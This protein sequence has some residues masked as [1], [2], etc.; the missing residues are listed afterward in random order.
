MFTGHTSKVT[1]L[2]AGALVTGIMLIASLAWNYQGLQKEFALQTDKQIQL[3]ASRIQEI[4]AAES[5]MTTLFMAGYY[6][7][8][9][10]FRIL[11]NDSMARNP[12]IRALIY[13]PRVKEDELAAHE[14]RVREDGI[15]AYSVRSLAMKKAGHYYPI[16]YL[17]PFT[18][19]S[20]RSLGI[21]IGNSAHMAAARDRT[22]ESGAPVI[23]YGDNLLKGLSGGWLIQA[24]YSTRSLPYSSELRQQ[25]AS[26]IVALLINGDELV[27]GLI[28]EGTAIRI[29]YSD[30][31]DNTLHTL[32][33]SGHGQLASM[34]PLLTQ[35]TRIP[36]A[37]RA[38]QLKLERSVS[39]IELVA[40][41]TFVAL[42]AG[43]ILTLLLLNL[44]RNRNAK[45][46]AEEA[47][48][49]S[50]AELEARVIERTRDLK[51]SNAQLTTEIRE[52]KH[53]QKELERFKST[54]DQT[55]DCVFMFDPQSLRFFYVNEGAIEQVGYSFDEMTAMTPLDIKPEFD[56]PRF[57]QMSDSLIK[58]PAHSHT[59]ETIHRHKDGH[60]IPVEIFLQYIEPDDTPPRFLAIVRDI[61]E[62][63]QAESERE[64]L[65]SYV[66]EV[67]DSMPSI[68]AG[69]DNTGHITHW[70]RQAAQLSGFTV[71][72][73]L[74]QPISKPLPMLSTK[75]NE[76]IDAV[77]TGKKLKLSRM[78]YQHNDETH[79]ADIL[80]YPL[81]LVGIEGA[82]LRIDDVTEQ[83]R[84]EE[85]MVQTEKMLSVGGLAGG[86]AHELN[87][88]IG[89]MVQG[90]QNIRRRLSTS[91]SKNTETASR[92]GISLE[93][94][95][96]Y[97][98]E[99]GVDK[100]FETVANAGERASGIVNNM[101]RFSRKSEMTYQTIQVGE[102][103][104]QT[105]AL[106]AV[107]Y[108]LTKQYDFRAIIIERDYQEGLPPFEC[109]P[110]ELQ[111]VIL[112]L[113]RNAAQAF[114]EQPQ[115][116]GPPCITLRTREAHGQ[117]EITVEDNGPGMDEMT[118]TRAFEPFF[119]TKPPG[120]GTGLGLSVSYYI[121]HDEHSGE[122]KVNSTPGNGAKF[123]ITLPFCRNE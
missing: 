107:D 54:L 78:S 73:A 102:L 116:A 108:D 90:I 19:L 43:A 47:L 63:R 115:A 36:L 76:L 56:E 1:A 39:I 65:H 16:R 123:T 17:E 121:I 11:A 49:K 27:S 68:V 18:P 109:I 93:Q 4:V 48:R 25:R 12:F 104:D 59:F 62:R 101:L 99:R 2:I 29:R 110:G 41:N 118:A 45:I 117:L 106:A 22:V 92:I 35:Q 13:A 53:A 23:T 52:R 100:L 111:Q 20:A 103:L 8:A 26:G 38:L 91:V 67:L 28:P 46:E 77:T 72:Q 3:V 14:A 71:E 88:P 50:H 112:N 120:Q 44:V 51:S 21:D 6:V 95:Q 105:V 42:P 61:T 7:D 33:D 81:K 82:V 58:G 80:L 30:Y 15:P 98:S 10:Q 74:G 5:A 96:Q 85:M 60:D 64:Q 83:T 119:S 32:H 97:M 9:D 24:L 37:D 94:L 87:N 75:V 66:N 86:M 70:N 57:R 89:G 113:L 31:Y 114:S 69:L 55:M 34:L 122:M 79:Y 84:M 40:G